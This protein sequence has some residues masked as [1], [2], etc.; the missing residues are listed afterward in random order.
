MISHMVGINCL[1]KA[2]FLALFRFIGVNCLSYFGIFN[3][4]CL[5]LTRIRIFFQFW[6]CL[7]HMLI[8]AEWG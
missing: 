7:S 4:V 1:E 5:I 2:D 6:F 3:F 8:D